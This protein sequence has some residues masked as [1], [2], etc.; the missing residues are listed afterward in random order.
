MILFLFLLIVSLGLIVWRVERK[1]S[2]R[3]DTMSKALD[4]LEYRFEWL[5]NKIGR[6]MPRPETTADDEI[7][8]RAAS[9]P[10]PPILPWEEERPPETPA[11][12]PGRP[13]Y[14]PTPGIR[15]D[16][17]TLEDLV[18]P[19]D[20]PQK[21]PEL[22]EKPVARPPV[23]PPPPGPSPWAERWRTFKSNVDWEL[24]T[25][26][27]LFAWL[28]G[29]AL[30]IAA[31]FFV[32]FSIDRNLIPPALRLAIGALFGIGLIIA[33]GRFRA[34][35][36][37]VTRHTLAA[38]GI[39]VL[40]SVV[41]AATL[42]YGYLS[43]PA[44]FGLLSLVSAAAFVLA[45]H[46]RGVS[47]SVLGALGAFA[48]PLL[49]SMGQD[50]LP[51][52]L[53]YLVVVNLGLFQVV[54]RLASSLLLLIAAAGTLAA[55]LLGTL[56]VY[57]VTS[58]LVVAACWIANLVLFSGFLWQLDIDPGKDR[59]FQWSGVLVFAANLAVAALMISNKPGWAPLLM[60]CVAQTAALGLTWRRRSWYGK[61]IPFSTLGFAAALAWVL[62]R[63]QPHRFSISLLLLLLYGAVGGLGPLLLI[64]RHGVNKW[65]VGWLR[66]FPVAIVM[67]GLAAIFQHGAVSFW[68]WPLLLGLE[69][70]G[71][72][73][74]LLLRAFV[75]V[76]LLLLMMLIGGMNWLFHMPAPMVGIG[77]FIF[78]LA[79]GVVL[80]LAVFLILKKLPGLTAALNLAGTADPVP[81]RSEPARQ[82]GLEEWLAAAPAGGVCLLLAASFLMPY[83]LYPHPGLATLV[84]FLV[85]VLFATHRLGLEIPG[86]AALMAAA[87]AQA[88]CVFR[89]P[90]GTDVHGAV[91][92]WSSVLFV[93]AL[94]APFVLFRS[95]A[96]WRRL[97]HAW[98]LFEALQAVFVLY[99]GHVL[100]KGQG[101]QW[102]PLLL[103][104]LKL[105]WVAVLLRRLEG[106]PERNSVLAFH[107]GVL[108]FYLSA[109]PV[110]VLNH[111][112][113]GLTF[114]F[115]ATALLWLNRRIHHPG[116]RWV[117]L[118]MAPVGLVILFINLPLLKQGDSLPVLN[119]AVLSVAACFPALA[120]AAG[121]AAYPERGLG[122]L[123]LPAY[124][125]WLSVAV[126]F[127]LV[128][129]VIAD[130][131]ALPGRLFKI[132]P[133][134]DFLQAV[135]Y[136]LAWTAAGGLTYRLL[137]LPRAI[138]TAGLI[139]V[140]LG[141]AG[142]I[143]LPLIDA[144]AVADMRPFIN[145][146][147]L[148]FL[149]LLAMLFYLF[150][151][152]P[153]DEH[154][155]LV[156][157]LLL[158]LFLAAGFM[159]LKMQSSIQL[160]TGYPFSLFTSRTLPRATASAAGWVVYGLA[161]HIWPR[162]LDRPFRLAGMSLVVIGLLKAL[163][164]P[165]R[166]K[167]AFGALTPLLNP[168][169]LVFLLCL[170][171]LAYLTLR[172]WNQSWPLPE[173]S[174]RLFWGIALAVTAFGVLNIEIASAFAIK[175]RP[176]SMLTHGS[177]AMQ[178]AYSIGWLLFAISL[179]VVGI[180]W[181][182][183]QVRWAAIGSIVITAVKI[184]IL[185]LWHLGQ[186]YR[187]GSFFGLAIVLILVSILYQRFLSEGEKNER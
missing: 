15:T 106:K 169:S 2:K 167:V 187:V 107:G 150:S 143:A 95:F 166:F 51:L 38:G 16:Q 129:L 121:K 20:E 113:I 149:P 24:F 152:E 29:V 74:S 40:Y 132:W 161:L 130:V 48:T 26:V 9:R 96:L 186:L 67:V 21:G 28:G 37:K 61:V 44:G 119:A 124:F 25:G 45:V 159:A 156:K 133:G 77:F 151:K 135:C 162:R 92:V 52:L 160:Q 134:H 177:L 183:V 148:A 141:S 97:W 153:W 165:L 91:L 62:L 112:W 14:S 125:Q 137:R 8:A 99:A 185:D 109:L 116:L 5:R 174:P 7:K 136:G 163:V 34:A 168:P 102:T 105:P 23:Q 4:S 80:C 122:K 75:Q 155:S 184:F 123:D 90:V 84:C 57:A 56:E 50:S 66:L 147:L 55:L 88:I 115:E 32:K 172:T 110:L 27:K 180:K 3:L 73:I 94:P 175:G 93:C 111:G 118:V 35:R 176:F 49:V 60:I 164:L 69:L 31:G 30:F 100:W 98:A 139:L 145:P 11:P 19:D 117:S 46:Y 144:R 114:V 157:N 146:G 140:G 81:G 178:L 42:Y 131:F 68:L 54:K 18:L 71:I 10:E 181:D 65:V 179:L 79:A 126:G 17:E 170:A 142:I 22:P 85:M 108:L 47:I 101:A 72:G 87:A 127:F 104:V 138:R 158:A 182:S 1:L 12:T 78:T 6:E 86:A 173:V 171:V 89:P 39:G 41:F 120:F 64:W 58:T 70:L 76:G 53:A 43:K 82:S 13:I 103:V 154:G 128:N 33:S 63:F 36:Y 59:A 83:P